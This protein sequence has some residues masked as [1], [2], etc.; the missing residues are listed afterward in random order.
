MHTYHNSV[1]LINIDYSLYLTCFLISYKNKI[2]LL[3]M[4]FIVYAFI[5][6]YLPKYILHSVN[7]YDLGN[8]NVAHN[9]V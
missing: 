2:Y 4:D 3:E 8:S 5:L 7:L 9:I 1:C 6:I